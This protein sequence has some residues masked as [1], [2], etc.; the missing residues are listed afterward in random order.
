MAELFVN[1]HQL[2]QHLAWSKLVQIHSERY[3]TCGWCEITLQHQTVFAS[4][5]TDDS[6]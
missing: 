3:R 6:F 5:T 4:K 2:C 1:I